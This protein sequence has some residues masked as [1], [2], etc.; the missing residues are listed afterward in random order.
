MK[1]DLNELWTGKYGKWLVIS[2]CLLF[3]LLIFFELS[4]FFLR[5]HFSLA[6]LDKAPPVVNSPQSSQNNTVHASLFGEYLSPDLNESDIKQSMLNVELVGIMFNAKINE[7][8]VIIR[9]AGGEE[10]GYRAGDKIPGG[11]LIKR[12]LTDGVLLEYQGALERLNL[13]KQELRFDPPPRP[14]IEE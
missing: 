11:A 2:G 10:R 5:D 8:Q 9:S 6:E 12:I 7:S 13:P 4:R 3:S 1:F 14:L